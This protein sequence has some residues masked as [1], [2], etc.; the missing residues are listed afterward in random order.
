MNSFPC[1]KNGGPRSRGGRG[2]L[3]SDTEY[4]GWFTPNLNRRLM[5]ARPLEV[6]VLRFQ[7]RV[8]RLK[9]YRPSGRCFALR[10]LACQV[11]VDSANVQR[12]SFQADV[13]T[14][15]SAFTTNVDK[16]V[17]NSNGRKCRSR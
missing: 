14:L 5:D 7:D 8:F 6:A 10:A 3:N 16:A 11:P 1:C 17:K 9:R 15:M 13:A 12:L 4:L 2:D